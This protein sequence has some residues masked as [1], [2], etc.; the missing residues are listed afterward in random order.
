[1]RSRGLIW[2][3]AL[4]AGLS[5][6]LVVPSPASGSGF[7]IF[8][9]GSKSMGMAG[10]FAAQADDGS[11]MFYNAGG[12]AFQ[13]ERSFD[14]GTTLISNIKGDFDGLAPFPGPNAQGQQKDAIF[15][16]SHAY[17]VQPVA[18]DWTFGV[19]FN[20]P[21]GLVVEWD[22]T[23]QWVGRF[24][25]YKAELRTFDLNPTIAWQATPDLGIG[26]GVVGRWSD[27]E[28]NQRLG[29]ANPLGGAA[30]VGDVRLESDL[31]EGYGWNAGILHHVSPRFSWGLSYRSKITVD[32]EGDGRFDQISTGNPAFDARVAS[33]IPFGEKLPITTSIEFPDLAM[34]GLAFG[35]T[36]NVMLETD[37]QWTG[38]SSF[39]KLDINFVDDP[40]FSR[41]IP[42]GYDDA[43]AYRVGLAWTKN[44]QTQWR[45][46]YVYDE[47][48]QPEEAVG[49]LL[50]D[51]NRNGF[52]V[53]YGY[54]GNW[55]LDVA[56]MYLIFDERTRDQT[57]QTNE[58]PNEPVFHGV[59]NTEAV[60]LGVTLGF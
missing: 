21:F 50:P 51:A 10:A 7:L 56:L 52:T 44:P 47:T 26:F 57:L 55:N 32:Y 25:S 9:H 18:Q 4:L 35:V 16:P 48:P 3:T 22:N 34:L 27:L 13:H 40:A 20:D 37:V 53:G 42:E 14:V 29:V 30:E 41:T 46:G 43:Y 15:Y 6:A 1:M 28:L 36:P 45:F 33:Q 39:D 12:L 11:A 38:W 5:I 23:D 24:I 2:T 59:Y 17:Y 58:F 8:E 60:L 49:P 19:G 54:Q 31:N